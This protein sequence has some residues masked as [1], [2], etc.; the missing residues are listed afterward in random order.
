MAQLCHALQQ[1]FPC[2]AESSNALSSHPRIVSS[3]A[4]G[5][6][7]LPPDL[8]ASNAPGRARPPP[9]LS[10]QN[11][12]RSIVFVQTCARRRIAIKTLRASG[13]EYDPSQVRAPALACAAAFADNL[14]H[15][16]P[17]LTENEAMGVVALIC[18]RDSIRP[19]KWGPVQGLTLGTLQNVYDYYRPKLPEGNPIFEMIKERFKEVVVDVEDDIMAHIKDAPIPSIAKQRRDEVFAMWGAPPFPP[20]GRPEDDYV[21]HADDFIRRLRENAE[22]AIL[23]QLQLSDTRA[24]FDALAEAVERE[25]GGTTTGSRRR[26]LQA[27]IRHREQ[28]EGAAQNHYGWPP[29]GTAATLCHAARLY[30]MELGTNHVV[31]DDFSTVAA[32]AL[33]AQEKKGEEILT[34]LGA[35]VNRSRRLLR[36]DPPPPKLMADGYR[37]ELEEAESHANLE[38]QHWSETLGYDS[39]IFL[40]HMK[41]ILDPGPFLEKVK[42]EV[43]AAA[44]ELRNLGTAQDPK[45]VLLEMPETSEIVEERLKASVKLAQ[46]S[47]VLRQEGAADVAD[48][49]AS[50]FASELEFVKPL[51]AKLKLDDEED[52]DGWHKPP[53]FEKVDIAYVKPDTPP[54]TPPPPPRPPTPPTGGGKLKLKIRLHGVT[55]EDVQSNSEILMMET[56]AG[57]I[58]AECGMPREWVDDIA[59]SGGMLDTIRTIGEPQSGYGGGPSAVQ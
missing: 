58:A 41:L 11:V 1:A 9:S 30:G 27:Q 50:E 55:L 48:S 8:S 4:P 7:D 46:L 35:D 33:M 54:P 6:A 45:N 19:D 16:N 40:K 32:R 59:V 18:G 15:P 34:P 2:D 3:N 47:S 21:P 5:R 39:L 12:I 29:R 10:A 44:T 52:D 24:A 43:E 38:L 53:G 22:K 37:I 28:M 51:I 56:C 13:G 57:I 26:V 14:L 36:A 42:E 23:E 20:G 17:W 49:M 25:L 31:V